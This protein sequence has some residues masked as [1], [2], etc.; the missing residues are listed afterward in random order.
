MSNAGGR[1]VGGYDYCAVCNTQFLF[2][3]SCNCGKGHG[4]AV[5]GGGVESSSTLG[6]SRVAHIPQGTTAFSFCCG[7]GK[8]AAV[9]K[10]CEC[11]IKPGGGS[12]ALLAELGRVAADVRE[13]CDPQL[14]VPDAKQDSSEEPWN[15]PMRS[16]HKSPNMTMLEVLLSCA[17][18]EVGPTC[19][20]PEWKETKRRI[21]A[22][23]KY[24]EGVKTDALESAA[25]LRVDALDEYAL[26]DLAWNYTV[27]GLEFDREGLVKF[28][29]ALLAAANRWKEI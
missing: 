28:C 19:D 6:S 21:I 1:G 10:P 14:I 3:G 24:C 7:C 2:G 29:N 8:V 27:G 5:R 26:V 13:R 23:I 20:E 22:C 15:E 17:D 9:G 11:S 18:D 16:Y 12:G 4:R 25:P